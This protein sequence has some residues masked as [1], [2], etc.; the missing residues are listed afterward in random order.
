ML[1][2]VMIISREHH[3]YPTPILTSGRTDLS[4][5]RVASIRYELL[6]SVS[7]NIINDNI[8][9]KYLRALQYSFFLIL[10]VSET[11]SVP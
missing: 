8:S 9:S 6:L 11:Y 4:Y 5:C 7:L 2:Y 10:P 3:V 1:C